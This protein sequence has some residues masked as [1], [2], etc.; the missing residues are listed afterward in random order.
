[1]SGS[2]T[3]MVDKG[4]G[5]LVWTSAEDP[6]GVK[7]VRA[8]CRPLSEVMP[9]DDDGCAEWP[10]LVLISADEDGSAGE[11]GSSE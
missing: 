10:W 1:M 3:I 6:S 4:L 11:D 9:V 5:V 2:V 8:V 7:V